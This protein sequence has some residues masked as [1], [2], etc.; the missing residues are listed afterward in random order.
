MFHLIFL[1]RISCVRACILSSYHPSS[2]SCVPLETCRRIPPTSG[3]YRVHAYVK[4][5]FRIVPCVP[6]IVA[7]WSCPRLC[8]DSCIDPLTP[9]CH[10]SYYSMQPMSVNCS[11]EALYRL[12]AS[13]VRSTKRCYVPIILRRVCKSTLPLRRVSCVRFAHYSVSAY[14]VGTY[15]LHIICLSIRFL[16]ILRW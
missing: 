6:L 5:L 14:S 3:R 8:R 7:S 15:G 11:I 16:Q 9:C 10:S 2:F 1:S 13:F 12:L 4:P